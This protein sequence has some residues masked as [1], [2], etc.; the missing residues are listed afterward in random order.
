MEPEPI[1]VNGVFRPT[2]SVCVHRGLQSKL[3]T[4]WRHIMIALCRV[5]LLLSLL[6]LSVVSIRAHCP[7]TVGFR[8]EDGRFGVLEVKREKTVLQRYFA[9]PN[10]SNTFYVRG[11]EFCCALE[12]QQAI[13]CF[14]WTIGDVISGGRVWTLPLEMIDEQWPPTTMAMASS[15]QNDSDSVYVG[16]VTGNAGDQCTLHGLWCGFVFQ[17]SI[18]QPGTMIGLLAGS[19]PTNGSYFSREFDKM[20]WNAYPIM[21]A[22][23]APYRWMEG[24]A[25]AEPTLTFSRPLQGHLYRDANAYYS[26]N[27]SS[28][29]SYA[30]IS[31]GI[32]FSED[33]IDDARWLAATSTS[34][35]CDWIVA[36]INATEPSDYSGIAWVSASEG[37]LRYNIALKDL[38]SP[39]IALSFSPVLPKRPCVGPS[40]SNDFFECQNGVWHANRSISIRN[41]PIA[42]ETFVGGTVKIEEQLILLYGP[43]T[44]FVAR[45]CI[46]LNGSIVIDMS[47]ADIDRLQKGKTSREMIASENCNLDN[48]ASRPIY[49]QTQAKKSCKKVSVTT[50]TSFG[51]KTLNVIVAMDHFSCNLWWIILISV[52]AGVLLIA[53]IVI[54]LVFSLS[55]K[56][57]QCA[58]PFSS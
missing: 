50:K 3:W 12:T 2:F 14:E 26:F 11:E 30:N 24:V 42:G 36:A 58:R 32:V 18:S 39:A 44:S 27:S 13:W 15:A 22:T 28:T 52:I 8:L 53:L 33:A 21:E 6:S 25:Q 56:A 45:D 23:V 57:R 5:L 47:Q 4:S 49:I 41:L 51:G 37:Y 54:V 48:L 19:G 46:E 31:S 29:I 7:G 16:L 10:C 35:S 43:Q 17:R 40:P 38:L 1:P 9:N 20:A 55:I 34:D